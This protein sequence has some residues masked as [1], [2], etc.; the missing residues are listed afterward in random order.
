MMI[1]DVAA[2]LIWQK[3]AR[4]VNRFLICRRPRHKSNAMLWEFAGGK[5]E[6]GETMEQALIRECREE[7]DITVEVGEQFM[8]V[9]HTYPDIDI[10]LGLFHCRIAE[11]VPKLLEH[12][13]LAWITPAEID[14]Y[15]F[16][17][18]DTAILAKIQEC[19][20]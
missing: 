18:A 7:L 14:R 16:C 10:R 12:E 11:G 9:Y 8:E 20:G 19:F 1:R 2:A 17:P 15:D 4:G 13:A 5:A 3:D 6:P